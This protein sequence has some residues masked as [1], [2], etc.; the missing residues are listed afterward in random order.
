MYLKFNIADGN[1]KQKIIQAVENGVNVIQWFSIDLD[2]KE[3]HPFIS[4]GPDINLVIDVANSIKHYN[5]I[6]MICIGGWNA[7]HPDTSVTSTA[8]FNAFLE[9]NEKFKIGEFTGFDG[10]DWDIEGNDNRDIWN[11]LDKKA[12]DFIGEFSQLAKSNGFLVSMAPAESY[13][14]PNFST[15]STSLVLPWEDFHPEFKYHGMNCYSYIYS[16]YSKTDDKDTFDWVFIQ[17]YESYAWRVKDLEDGLSPSEAI[18]KAVSS[19]ISGWNIDYSSIWEGESNHFIRIPP[20][21]FVVGL[22]GPW[23][24]PT[25]TFFIEPKDCEIA[26][27]TLKENGHDILGFGFWNINTEGQGDQSIFL[28]KGLNEFL[29]IRQ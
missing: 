23:A 8:M 19:Y 26:Y 4:R 12:L 25:K 13:F 24:D 3:S 21:K 17:F 22:S 5:A 9:F 6:H 27:R 15:F 20:S 11:T 18:F 10:I 7:K 1:D 16:K 2:T 14:D 29:K 28:A